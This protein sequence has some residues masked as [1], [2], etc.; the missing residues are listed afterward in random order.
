M[1]TKYM[2]LCAIHPS[3]RMHLKLWLTSCKIKASQLVFFLADKF[4]KVLDFKLA[5]GM[6]QL[7]AA[8]KETSFCQF[9]I[10]SKCLRHENSCSLAKCQ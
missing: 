1:N 6:L 4:D 10:I 5:L 8:S 2:V 9:G 7:R 3:F